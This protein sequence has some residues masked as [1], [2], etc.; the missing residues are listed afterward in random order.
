MSLSKLLAELR[1]PSKSA[2]AKA[3]PPVFKVI[4]WISLAMTV[5][6]LIVFAGVPILLNNA[7]FHNYVIGTAEEQASKSLG[8]G[9]HLQNFALHF[10]TLSVDVYGITI[11][12]ASPYPNPPLLQTDHVR[13]DIRIVSILRKTW[14][15]ESF[16]LDHPVVHVF[17]D[18][19]GVSNI[20]TIKSS[21]QSSSTSVFD[22]G[23]RHATLQ[24]GEI[25][26]NNKPA[27]IAADLHDG[28]G[29]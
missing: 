10:S 1:D 16:E 23:V 20:P 29:L 5:V 3:A 13:T 25:Y 8:V 14:Y 12:G 19:K 24:H 28:A 22:L 11:D 2:L 6:T 9:V 15:L 26:Y 7:R 4:A 18:S 27:E 21:G 17:V